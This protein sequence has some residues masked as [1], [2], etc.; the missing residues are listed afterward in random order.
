MW[1]SGGQRG[2][3]AA[4]A[5]DRAESGRYGPADASPVDSPHASGFSTQ[6]GGRAGVEV[7]RFGGGLVVEVSGKRTVSALLCL[8]CQI[9]F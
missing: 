7:R 3:Q 9:S 2:S 6:A 8:P 1:T 4:S 5:K